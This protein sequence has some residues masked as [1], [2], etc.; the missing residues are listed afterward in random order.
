M[1]LFA[2]L[3]IVAALEQTPLMG[4]GEKA[5]QSYAREHN[6][7]KIMACTRIISIGDRCGVELDA[8][9]IYIL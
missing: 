4:Y 6:M 5:K 7:T 3:Q 8:I 2:Y 1:S 9:F